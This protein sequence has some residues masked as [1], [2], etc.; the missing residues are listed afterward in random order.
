MAAVTVTPTPHGLAVLL[1]DKAGTVVVPIFIGGTEALSIDMRMRH[2]PR[3]RPL[4]HD[5]LDAVVRELGGR[6]IKVQVDDVR[7]DVFFGRVFVRHDGR[8]AEIDARP[9]DAIALAVGAGVPIF[10]SK[11]VVREAGIYRDGAD[12]DEQPSASLISLP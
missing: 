8:I 4:T 1:S 11:R 10:V 7:D 12:P 2:E 6:L 3:E 9:S 5:L